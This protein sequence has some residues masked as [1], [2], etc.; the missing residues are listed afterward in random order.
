MIGI[1]DARHDV[2]SIKRAAAELG[3]GDLAVEKRLELLHLRA[4]TR[5]F[6]NVRPRG[7]APQPPPKVSQPREV[8]VKRTRSPPLCPGAGMPP[9]GHTRAQAIMVPSVS[10]PGKR[11][12][13]ERDRS[14]VIRP[15]VLVMALDRDA[16]GST[17]QTPFFRKALSA[18]WSIPGRASRAWVSIFAAKEGREVGS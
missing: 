11:N 17:H 10:P 7:R 4:P 18:F 13:P 16:P 15:T 9:M 3:R 2:D 6:D 5:F 8:A 12:S 14:A 1:Y